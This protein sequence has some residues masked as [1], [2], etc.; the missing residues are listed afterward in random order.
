MEKR[1]QD[2]NGDG[3]VRKKTSL[4]LGD[5]KGKLH[6]QAILNPVNFWLALVKCTTN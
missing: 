5:G 6:S 1:K 3:P 4:R 2:V